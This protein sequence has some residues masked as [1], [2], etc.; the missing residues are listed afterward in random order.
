KADAMGGTR[1]QAANPVSLFPFLAVL[2][3]AMGALIFLLLV[4]TH[5]IRQQAVVR[6]RAMQALDSREADVE[7]PPV[8]P[9]AEPEPEPE[10][11]P[12]VTAALPPALEPRI[13][14]PV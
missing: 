1:Q 3:C 8:V 5:R 10:P 12:I 7:P 11:E 6:A 14:A 9:K 4:T 2:V 13:S